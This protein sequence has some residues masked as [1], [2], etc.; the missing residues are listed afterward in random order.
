MTLRSMLQ[1]ASGIESALQKGALSE[2][3]PKCSK[4][5]GQVSPSHLARVVEVDS[6]IGKRG[7]P[8]SRFRPTRDSGKREL[9][10]PGLSVPN[11]DR[12]SHS[13]NTGLVG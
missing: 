10:I 13:A 3:T 11:P 9:G 7:F 5:T 2:A 8:A 6:L 4:P 12:A 1:L